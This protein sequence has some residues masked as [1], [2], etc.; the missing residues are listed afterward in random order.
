MR[1]VAF[2]GGIN[3]GGHRVTMDRLR[4]ELAPLGDGGVSTFIASGNVILSSRKR[5]A[6]LEAAIEDR[7]VDALG[8]AVPTFVRRAT[9]LGRIA[10]EEPWG[11][12]P[13]GH[14]L[15]V[16]FLRDEPDGAATA[17]TEALSNDQDR[18]AVLG[19]ELYQQVRGGFSDSSVR[20][21]VLARALGRP[22]TA[23][24]RTS[25]RKLVA[26]L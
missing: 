11:A 18:F 20:P 26:T 24:N 8:Y 7:L 22:A 25:L 10:A 19:T 6:T 14:T 15:V 17:A 2:L 13:D 21:A 23:R 1:Y 5:A 16:W 3:V 9:D 4:Q 12:V